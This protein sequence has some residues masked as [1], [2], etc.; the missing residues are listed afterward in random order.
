VRSSRVR[1]RGRG[2]TDG[3]KDK[4]NSNPVTDSSSMP[5]DAELEV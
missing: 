1:G 5:G 4:E 3:E 2:K